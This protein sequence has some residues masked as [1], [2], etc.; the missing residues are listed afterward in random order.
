[1]MS[2]CFQIQ[3]KEAENIN[4]TF[5]KSRIKISKNGNLRACKV[6]DLDK[7]YPNNAM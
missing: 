4:V 5:D 2:L 3:L 7:I 6:E 1:M